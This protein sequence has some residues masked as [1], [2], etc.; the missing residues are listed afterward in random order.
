MGLTSF[1]TDS[2]G[3][4]EDNPRFLR[5]AEPALKRLQRRV[6]KKKPVRGQPAS[7]NFLKAR[8]HLKV[9]RQR[10]DHAT[11]LARC[12]IRSHDLVAYEVLQIRNMVKNHHLAK[13]ISDASWYASRVLLESYANL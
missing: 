10:R 8:K 9:S 3:R 6:S 2:N 5:K 13:S 1:Y 4:K 12:A 11:K 7:R